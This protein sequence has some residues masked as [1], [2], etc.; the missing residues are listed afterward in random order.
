MS[1]ESRLRQI[2]EFRTIDGVNNNPSSSEHNK[3]HVWNNDTGVFDYTLVGENHID[4]DFF[5]T[6]IK[7]VIGDTD[8]N[9]YLSS[10]SKEG[11]YGQFTLTNGTNLYLEL[12]E[13]AWL[14][15]IPPSKY[16]LGLPGNKKVLFD[17]ND[18]LGGEDAFKYDKNTNRVQFQGTSLVFDLFSGT[19]GV[20][21]EGIKYLGNQ[22]WSF[23]QGDNSLNSGSYNLFGG[24]RAGS[25]F[26]ATSTRN[27]VL[28]IEAGYSAGNNLEGSIFIGPFSGKYETASNKFFLDN[29]DYSN[30]STARDSSFMYAD[31]DVER[32]L[33]IRDRL[34]V[35]KEGKFG[36]SGLVDAEGEYGM[37]QMS[38]ETGGNPQWHDGTVWQDFANSTNTYLDDVTYS[39]GELTFT[40]SD[41]STIGPIDISDINT[42]LFA[43]S[44]SSPATGQ[45]ASSDYGYIQ[46]SNSS[47]TNNEG[48]TYRT[49]FRISGN[50]LYLPGSLVLTASSSTIDNRIWSDGIH[51]YITLD[52]T[53]YQIDNDPTDETTGLNIGGATYELYKQKNTDGQLEFRT[54]KNIP[55]GANN[56]NDRIKFEYSTDGDAIYIGTTAEKNR[57]DSQPD[58]AFNDVVIDKDNEGETLLMRA[59]RPGTGVTLTQNEDYIQIDATGAG[60]GEVNTMNNNGTGLEFYG[61]KNGAQFEMYTLSTTDSRIDLDPATDY[62]TDPEN[63]I[64]LNLSIE[65][66]TTTLVSSATSSDT[67]FH[68]VSNGTGIAPTIEFK[69]LISDTLT[70]TTTANNELQIEYGSAANATGT[71]TGSASYEVYKDGTAPDF[72]FRSLTAVTDK[73]ITL[74]Y[75]GDDITFAVDDLTSVYAGL[76][77]SKNVLKSVEGF[78]ITS[79][80]IGVQTGSGLDL[81][82]STVNDIIIDLPYNIPSFTFTPAPSFTIGTPTGSGGNKGLL[83]F[84]SNYSENIKDTAEAATTLFQLNI[85]DGLLYDSSTNTLYTNQANSG[86]GTDN[87]LVNITDDFTNSNFTDLADIQTGSYLKK[88]FNIEDGLDNTLH[89]ID[90]LIPEYTLPIAG[91]E[92]GDIG[93]I[94]I[95]ENFYSWRAQQ[96]EGAPRTQP[97]YYDEVSG[98]LS[99]NKYIVTYTEQNYLHDEDNGGGLIG[100]LTFNQYREQARAN[101]GSAYVNGSSTEDF[102][103]KDLILDGV[104]N[105]ESLNE[106]VIGDISITRAKI[107][108]DTTANLVLTG[109]D[110][111]TAPSLELRQSDIV[112]NLGDF[113]FAKI[114]IK[115]G[116]G[117][118][119]FKLDSNGDLYIKGSIRTGGTVEVFDDGALNM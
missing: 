39:G 19:E 100:D 51:G 47:F 71:N 35:A 52:G 105:A 85:G 99:G 45:T 37:Y 86:G 60:G 23:G 49:G 34:S 5:V 93:G 64:G 65:G 112:L 22:S 111:T 98:I 38:A 40:L 80:G 89:T 110:E 57:L 101:I 15:E 62:T 30:T 9:T 114:Y 11:S 59:L 54:L 67:V 29:T 70:F 42:T 73:H 43:T 61:D 56:P 118:N 48:L 87:Y 119:L 10:I 113:N 91:D 95:Q 74:G 106:H 3:F 24:Y 50:D 8:T 72:E 31:L 63:T 68:Q 13:L 115:D 55:L 4:I 92:T 6:F 78:E 77:T 2:Y 84:K 117:N 102:N 75:N 82:N 83:E 28:G 97:L 12:G 116:S 58:S 96:T 109:Y 69:R 21:K 33:Y 53:D 79:K 20:Y 7:E 46:I 25:S 1:G 17:D 32:R 104:I 88:T 66:D 27:L 26:G 94:K 14:D 18:S 81:T 107:K 76:G 108:A 103:A 90:T 44:P 41:A 16:D 36:T